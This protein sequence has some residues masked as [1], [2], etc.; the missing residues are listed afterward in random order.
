GIGTTSV[1]KLGAW[2]ARNG[3]SFDAAIASAADA[4]LSG[5][6]LK[7]AEELAATLTELRGMLGSAG[8]GTLVQATAERTG[9]LKEL[10]AERSHEA[11]GRIE[12][13]AELVG[14]AE[15]YEDLT[16]LLE[17]VA[18]VAD[19][20]ELDAQSSRVNLMTLHTAKGLEF[21]A[22]FLVG[23]E[24]GIFPHF[25]SL[26]EPLELEEERRLCYVGI[27]RARRWLYLSHAWVRTL[28]GS[29]SHNIP[30]RFLAEVPAE[31]VRD[32]GVV[33]GRA[34][35]SWGASRG[36][37][38]RPYGDDGWGARSGAVGPGGWRSDDDGPVFGSG[39]GPVPGPPR[40]RSSTGAEELAL[41]PGDKVV[42]A[43]WGDGVVVSTVGEGDKAQ[44]KVRFASVG[45]KRLLLS[46]TPLK[47]A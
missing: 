22:V 17:T 32:V 41:T 47:R 33:G 1:A 5:K 45:E 12:N 43:H 29:T 16:E 9:Y 10:V 19:S 34:G 36:T 31:L 14:V 21:P 11:D 39:R 3:T 27:T 7:G 13:I 15:E 2:A 4:G 38:G 44:A 42:H 6:A 25:R 18:L 20:D 23:L 24:D 35:G 37:D 28:W 26:A 40:E 30:S 8:P 46:A